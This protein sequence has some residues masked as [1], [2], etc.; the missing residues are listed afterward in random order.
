MKRIS[1]EPVVKFFII[2]IG[3]VTL[4]SV[5]K[6]L[7]FI[8]VP[9]VIAYLLVFIFLPLNNYLIKKRIPQVLTTIIDLIIILTF[10]W[11]LS[12]FIFDA[13][14]RFSQELPTYELKLNSIIQQT[15]RTLHIEDKLLVEFNLSE[16]LSELDY[17]GILGGLFT[18]TLSF[19]SATFL[20]LFFFIFVNS[21]Y[22]QIIGSIKNRFVQTR[23]KIS[24][25]GLKKKGILISVEENSDETVRKLELIKAN[26]EL[27]VEK[28]FKDITHKIQRYI[29]MKFIISLA[30]AIFVGIV[31]WIFDVEF[32]LVWAVLTFF[33]NFIPNIGSI[34]AIILPTLMTL[35]QYESIG[36]TLLIGGILSLIQNL[37]GNIIEPKLMG[38]RL[39]LNPLVILLALLL[40]GYL[41]G[42]PGMFLSVPLTAVI[43][44]IIS[45]SDSPNLKFLNDLLSGSLSENKA[46]K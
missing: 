5:L 19:F 20:I 42:I 23:S 22:N 13:F 27:R 6:E 46:K 16:F 32:L 11:L 31:L 30:T 12:N 28:T 4:F 25:K 35:I 17:G 18:S 34:I 3:L 39:G 1:L 41:W 33:L 38:D 24:T 14:K 43:Q 10:F 37:I 26:K 29:A 21:S 40:W 7:Q 45:D 44:I 15:A 9:L 2:I 8:F 36:Y